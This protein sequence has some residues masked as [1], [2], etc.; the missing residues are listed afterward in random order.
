MLY[1]IV[2]THSGVVFMLYVTDL[3]CIKAFMVYVID[4]MCILV[5]MVSVIYLKCYVNVIKC[6][7]KLLL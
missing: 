4:L 2:L 5:F 7:K 6:A 3:I 1:V